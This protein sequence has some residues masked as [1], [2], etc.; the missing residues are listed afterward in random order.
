MMLAVSALLMLR[1]QMSV[2]NQGQL[3]FATFLASGAL[4][5]H[6][7]A[8]RESEFASDL[9]APPEF[10]FGPEAKML[11][12]QWAHTERMPDSPGSSSYLSTEVRY[13]GYFVIGKSLFNNRG[14]LAPLPNGIKV[15]KVED[16]MCLSRCKIT[17]S[18]NWCNGAG[19]SFSGNKKRSAVAEYLFLQDR[20]SR[21]IPVERTTG[22]RLKLCCEVNTCEEA[23]E[24]LNFEP[25]DPAVKVYKT[26]HQCLCCDPSIQCDEATNEELCV[27]KTNLEDKQHL[28]EL[29]THCSAHFQTKSV[30]VRISTNFLEANVPAVPAKSTSWGWFSRCKRVCTEIG[31]IP[32]RTQEYFMNWDSSEDPDTAEWE[33][34]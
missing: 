4:L 18:E 34:M 15:D 19:S 11:D 27:D 17:E 16:N 1:I 7:S 3:R 9:S 33:R 10:Q 28:K 5:H 29:D 31:K 14:T 26:P 22:I 21:A 12:V 32:K 23:P 20:S 6:S 13:S 2:A 25:L 8:M 24:N 30:N